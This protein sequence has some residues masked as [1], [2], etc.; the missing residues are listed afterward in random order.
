ML[1]LPP[2]MDRREAM[3]LM[4]AALAL[5]AGGCA[6]PPLDQIVPY[7]E[8]QEGRDYGEPLYFATALTQGGYAQGILARSNMGRPTKIE[9]NPRH[10]ASL[11]ATTPIEQGRILELWDP[12]RSR[13]VLH[14]G[15][16]ASWDELMTMLTARLARLQTSGGAGLRLLTRS[17]SSPTLLALIDAVLARYSQ[18]RWHHHEPVN[19]DNVHEGARLAFGRPLEPVYHFDRAVTVLS[20]EAD[21][22]GCMPGK[23]RHARDYMQLR[24]P[25]DSRSPMSRLYAVECMPSLTGAN[26]DYRLALPSSRIGAVAAELAARLSRGGKASSAWLESAAADL[27][28]HRGSSLILAGEGQPAQV[29]AL[30][31]DMNG[32]LGNIG[33][34]VD[35][36]QPPVEIRELAGASLAALAA[37]MHAGRVD[38]LL[39]LDGNPVYDAP[40]DLEFARALE[41]VPASI[42]HGLLVDETAQRCAWHVPAAHELETW[43]DARAFDGTLTIQQPLIA[44]LY[45]GKSAIELLGLLIG[46][47]GYVSHDVV[48]ATWRQRFGDQQLEQRWREALRTGIVADSASAFEKVTAAENPTAPPAAHAERGAGGSDAAPGELEIVFRPD[49]FLWDGRYAQ[50]AWLQE[51]PRPLTQLTWDNAAMMCPR[52][53]AQLGVQNEELVELELE[54]R[55]AEA[56]VWI[57]PGHADDAVTMMLGWGRTSAGTVGSLRGSSAYAL[58]S[59]RAPWF[60]RGVRITR[61]GRRRP[62]ASVQGHHGME[63]RDI[64]RGASLAAYR[65]NSGFAKKKADIEPPESLY[66]DVPYPGYAWGMSID[67]TSCIGC[68]ACTI[69]C[70]AENNIPTVGKQQV[71]VGREMHWIRVDRYDEGPPSAPRTAFQPVPCMQCE[72]APC[73]AVCPVEASVH[74]AEGIN[75]QVYNRCIG[76]RFCENNCPYKVRR[77]NFFGYTP[78]TPI[79]DAMRNPDVTVRTRGVMEKCNY[80]LQRVVRAR[81]VADRENRTLHDGE[82]VTACQAVCPTQAIVFGDLNDPRSQVRIAKSSPRNYALLGDLDT[83]PRT[84][85]LARIVNTAADEPV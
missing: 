17:S 44:P 2:L 47:L 38:T 24:R 68:G 22:L 83:R 53:A 66:P 41:R 18:A 12:G 54:G 7:L 57:V 67:L 69:A 49:P 76:T 3:K 28:S 30:A 75:V 59:S 84:T 48:R 58:R 6:H 36:I 46:E 32:R 10:P 5:A 37:D 74:D 20:L 71:L 60:A 14:D 77:F 73:E 4:S 55:V 65:V 16:I 82:V 9:G 45:G 72:H 31:H 62:L 39:I 33:K 34:T 8:G 23:V 50:V 26:A 42:H 78:N 25:D 81:I 52:L 56:P 51:L 63:G 27:D 15:E 1:D 61:T 19:R 13:A 35:F 85:Y 70:Q 29:H 80:C 43:G 64:V 79:L 40:A 21:F 11:G